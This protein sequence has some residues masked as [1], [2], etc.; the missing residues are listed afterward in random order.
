M[1]TPSSILAWE[2]PWTEEPGGL[3][4]MGLPRVGHDLVPEQRPPGR[5]GGL[6]HVCVAAWCWPASFLQPRRLDSGFP[7]QER[8]ILFHSLLLRTYAPRASQTRMFFLSV[9]LLS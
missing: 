4:S 1:A 5:S 6:F 8:V 9:A 7:Q 3:Q 2:V